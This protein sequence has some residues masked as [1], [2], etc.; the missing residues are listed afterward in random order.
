[1][2]WNPSGAAAARR[3]VHVSQLLQATV[4]HLAGITWVFRMHA[5]PH[6]MLTPV[7][8]SLL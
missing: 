2:L 1:M 4:G 3:A 6:R 7:S 8:V 5:A